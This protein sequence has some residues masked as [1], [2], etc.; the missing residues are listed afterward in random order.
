[1]GTDVA[2]L[3]TLPALDVHNAEVALAGD[4]AAT[5][6][7]GA[8]LQVIVDGV[9]VRYPSPFNQPSTDTP[10]LIGTNRN[11]ANIEYNL[12]APDGT[13]VSPLKPPQTLDELKPAMAARFNELW[14]QPYPQPDLETVRTTYEAEMAAR[15]EDNSPRFLL[16]EIITD[17]LRRGPSS[18]WAAKQTAEGRNP[19]YLY[20]LTSPLVPP[21]EGTPHTTD[22]PLLFGTNG[23]PYLAERIGDS[24]ATNAVSK[25]LRQAWIAFAWTGSPANRE[26]GRWRPYSESLR[27]VG[28]IGGGSTFRIVEAPRKT[29][30]DT[31]PDFTYSG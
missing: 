3:R 24:A 4:K 8:I 18:H 7:I 5:G 28:A 22:I 12:T 10:M 30:M 21:G 31:M 1:M 11:E 14:P 2:G 29:Q 15:G 17:Q 19:A 6:S 27:E 20:E 16:P 13:V 9:T 26:T 25:A 23:A